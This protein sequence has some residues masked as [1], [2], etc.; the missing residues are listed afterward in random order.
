MHAFGGLH[1]VRV[2][3]DVRNVVLGTHS[4]QLFQATWGTGSSMFN[5]FWVTHMLK[6]HETPRHL[7]GTRGAKQDVVEWTHRTFS[8]PSSSTFRS[9]ASKSVRNSSPWRTF[10]TTTGSKP[11]E[12]G[13]V[14]FY[15]VEKRTGAAKKKK[16]RSFSSFLFGRTY[17][18]MQ[19][20]IKRQDGGGYLHLLWS[21]IWNR[22]SGQCEAK[23]CSELW[24][25]CDGGWGSKETSSSLLP[26]EQQSNLPHSEHLKYIKETLFNKF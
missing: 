17:L 23:W 24:V 1:A 25:S 12:I 4:R 11:D 20:L 19:F 13:G 15:E 14:G 10:S 7:S 18:Q 26:W 6:T 16:I 9:T 8:A 21:W 22:I 3:D 5:T 2:V